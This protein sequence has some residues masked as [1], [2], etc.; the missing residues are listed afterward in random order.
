MDYYIGV[1]S[2]TSVDGCDLAYV[3][4]DKNEKVIC[5]KSAFYEIDKS[6]KDRILS[7]AT[8]QQISIDYYSSLE[9]DLSLYYSSNI[10]DFLKRNN[11]K[12]EDIKAVSIHGQTVW[13]SPPKT[14][15]LLNGNIILANTG[16]TTVCDF[17]RLDLALGGEGAP[18]V[19]AF[20]K[21]IFKNDNNKNN[22]NKNIVV[23]N[24][25]GIANI[26]VIKDDVVIG[27]DTGP[28][29]TLIDECTRKYFSCDFD[30][31]AINAKKGKINNEL[32]NRLLKD[33]YFSKL[34][35]KSTGREYFNFSWLEKFDIKNINKYDLLAT[36]TYLS[37]KTISIE[38]KKFFLDGN[39]IIHGGG[40]RNPLLL[41]HLK[42]ELDGFN[43]KKTDEF[44]FDSD[45]LE[46][47]AF[48]WLAHMR[49][50]EIPID[51]TK[52]TGASEKHLFGIV[53]KNK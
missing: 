23:L 1:M 4:I 20:H 46:A 45:T 28:A 36:L 11:L 14:I 53:Y 15:Q 17:R 31:D 25:G 42:K 3:S 29:N 34:Y 21:H 22:N 38:I 49:L 12:K 6:L 5:E 47:S 7:L 44:G 9:H 19:P 43:I 48:A 32:L 10:C 8:N 24:M 52:I 13:H 51:M 33:D 35:P 16:I 40:A 39:L 50:K 41:S 18:L 26:T 27:Y 2:G 37:A 30:K